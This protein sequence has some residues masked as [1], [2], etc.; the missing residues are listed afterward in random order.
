[1]VGAN[2]NDRTPPTTV[3]R[4]GI[5]HRQQALIG[6]EPSSQLPHFY[7]TSSEDEELQD[8]RVENEE[9]DGTGEVDNVTSLRDEDAQ[10]GQ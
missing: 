3:P 7:P 6:D 4:R 1:M 10:E 9:Q 8:M 2:Y 5:H